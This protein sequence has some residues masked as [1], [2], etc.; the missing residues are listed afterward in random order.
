[1]HFSWSVQ[2]DLYTNY[3]LNEIETYELCKIDAAKCVLQSN[4][5][6]QVCYIN[7]TTA[8]PIYLRNTLVFVFSLYVKIS[9][10]H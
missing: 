2:Y 1:M 7:N 10:L 5:F 6:W 9:H 3:I 8:L 4:A